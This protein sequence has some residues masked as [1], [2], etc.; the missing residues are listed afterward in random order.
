MALFLKIEE[1]ETDMQKSCGKKAKKKKSVVA[2][3]ETWR[4]EVFQS[5]KALY[6]LPLNL[7]T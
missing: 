7:V 1:A 5:P 6:K 3:E 2:G 4:W